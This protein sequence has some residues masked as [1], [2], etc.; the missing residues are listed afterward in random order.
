M[1]NQE[2]LTLPAIQ[3]VVDRLHFEIDQSSRTP[4][5]S[6]WSDCRHLNL[7][8]RIVHLCIGL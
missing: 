7:R 8:S 5:K 4:L 3:F 6:R 2:N 1:G